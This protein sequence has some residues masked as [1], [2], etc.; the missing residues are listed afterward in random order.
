MFV[1]YE[2]RGPG[3]RPQQEEPPGVPRKDPWILMWEFGRAWLMA[4]LSGSLYVRCV[5]PFWSYYYID[6]RDR[7]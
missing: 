4:V 2:D 3:P 7:R 5:Y 1:R 6:P